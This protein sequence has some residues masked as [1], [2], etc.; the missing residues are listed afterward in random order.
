MHPGGTHSSSLAITQK[1]NPL[2][3]LITPLTGYRSCKWRYCLLMENWSLYPGRLE[4][5]PGTDKVCG[6]LQSAHR[7]KQRRYIA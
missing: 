1:E 3:K 7:G 6:S 2:K 5:P 4:G